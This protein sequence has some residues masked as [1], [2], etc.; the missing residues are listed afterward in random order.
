M[1]SACHC[2][3]DSEARDQVAANVEKAKI[4][5]EKTREMAENASQFADM[6]RK[7]RE[8]NERSSF[9]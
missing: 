7:I 6:A 5:E 2:V 8:K 3:R 9:W 4:L 1:R